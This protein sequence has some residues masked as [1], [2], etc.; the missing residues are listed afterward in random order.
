[1]ELYLDGDDGD[2]CWMEMHSMLYMY[3]SHTSYVRECLVPNQTICVKRGMA[4]GTNV[5]VCKYSACVCL[6]IHTGRNRT[7]GKELVIHAQPQTRD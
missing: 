1:M 4:C 5:C 3:M 6:V 2:A 7:R